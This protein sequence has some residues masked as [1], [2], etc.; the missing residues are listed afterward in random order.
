MFP[1]IIKGIIDYLT[2]DNNPSDSTL[3]AGTFNFP[4]TFTFRVPIISKGGWC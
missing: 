3:L 2:S 1:F 4:A